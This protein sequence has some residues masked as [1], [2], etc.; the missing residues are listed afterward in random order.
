LDAEG[1]KVM[2]DSRLNWKKGNRRNAS[3]MEGMRV[4]VLQRLCNVMEDAKKEGPS[5][6]TINHFPKN[7]E[8]LS[9]LP[10]PVSNQTT[11]LPSASN[12]SNVTIRKKTISR[13]PKVPPGATEGGLAPFGELSPIILVH[14][15]SQTEVIPLSLEPYP[16]RISILALRASQ[17]TSQVSLLLS[18]PSIS[19]GLGDP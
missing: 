15:R 6:D 5:F 17:L 9:P 12:R 11:L 7:V 13:I 4:T 3:D 14:D 18:Y 19:E 10:L 16:D 8:S 1:K 2:E